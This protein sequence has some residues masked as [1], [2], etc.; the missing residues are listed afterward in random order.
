MKNIVKRESR[1]VFQEVDVTYYVT[2]DGAEFE[3][4]EEAK[5]H[6]SLLKVNRVGVGIDLPASINFYYVH[7][8]REIETIT[9]RD[10]V[11]NNFEELNE[12]NYPCWIGIGTVD[13]YS[14]G[15]EDYLINLAEVKEK[16]EKFI[17]GYQKMISKIE[18]PIK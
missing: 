16:C 18:E 13:S 2:N 8:Q 1:N 5:R 9:G 11:E 15:D 6:E 3:Y 10:F 4:I 17:K 14:Y 12:Y 7:D